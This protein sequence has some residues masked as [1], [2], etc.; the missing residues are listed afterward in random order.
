[1]M[2]VVSAFKRAVAVSEF[3]FFQTT[4]IGVFSKNA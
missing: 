1:M 4:C 2:F 3:I